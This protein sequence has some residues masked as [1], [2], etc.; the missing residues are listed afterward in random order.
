MVIACTRK[1]GSDN[2]V[3]KPGS[4]DGVLRK[5]GSGDNVLRKGGSGEI[6]EFFSWPEECHVK[7]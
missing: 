7:D 3:C 6:C 5:G 4:G 2:S 1:G